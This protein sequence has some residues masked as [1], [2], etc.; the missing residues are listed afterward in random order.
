MKPLHV[1]ISFAITALASSHA[2]T[3]PVAGGSIGDKKI[4]ASYDPKNFKSEESAADLLLV[5]KSGKTIAEFPRI[6]ADW[7]WAGKD[8]ERAIYRADWNESGDLV[9]IT[10]CAG[11]IASDF[12]VYRFTGDKIIPINIHAV[13]T[14]LYE[15]AI[16][17]HGPRSPNNSGCHPI[18]WLKSSTLLV[19]LNTA[20]DL[21][22]ATV[23][24]TK[25]NKTRLTSYFHVSEP[26]DDDGPSENKGE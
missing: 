22:Y 14:P 24:I 6:N 8:L 16:I 26:T 1:I 3:F 13:V 18:T 9:F 15:K 20:D 12:E 21:F 2:D 23:S 7:T 10:Y 25:Q 4:V 11:R 19:D 5:D 17:G